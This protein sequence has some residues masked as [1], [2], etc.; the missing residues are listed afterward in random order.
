MSTRSGFTRFH[1]TVPEEDVE[2]VDNFLPK[3]SIDELFYKRSVDYQSKNKEAS[4][5]VSVPLI[6][7]NGPLKET[8]VTASK[9]LFWPFKNSKV[10]DTPIAS[11]AAKI[12]YISFAEMFMNHVVNCPTSSQSSCKIDC[13]SPEIDC[14]L[15]DNN[16]FIVVHDRDFEA[17]DGSSGLVRY[18]G[19]FLGEFD[20]NLFE[21][22]ANSNVFSRVV[23]YDYQAICITEG[24]KRSF[25][26]KVLNPFEAFKK[27]ILWFLAKLA[28]LAIKLYFACD[29]SQSMS[30][31]VYFTPSDYDYEYM[32]RQANLEYS[33]NTSGNLVA[34]ARTV[35]YPCDESV[36]L[37]EAQNLKNLDE[38]IERTYSVSENGASCSQ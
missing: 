29:T 27:L 11:F 24:E 26:S 7:I 16:G 3:K 10:F 23:I 28:T 20:H 8:F 19:M 17:G 13:S 34:P 37:Y 5:V 12:D 35:F 15:V 38:P 31:A 9:S 4:Y 18:A 30:E 14:L 21:D 22:L 33:N 1:Q 6:S 2:W 36:E 32:V 25:A